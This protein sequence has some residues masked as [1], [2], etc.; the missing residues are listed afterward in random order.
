[1][2]DKASYSS[3]SNGNIAFE[4]GVLEKSNELQ[5]SCPDSATKL[6]GTLVS[7]SIFLSYKLALG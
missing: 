3:M 6:P 5:M 2:I 4:V 7:H 1:M